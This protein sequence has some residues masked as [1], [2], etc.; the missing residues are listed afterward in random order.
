MRDIRHRP[1]D[2]PMMMGA[3]GGTVRR[4]EGS[5]NGGKKRAHRAATQYALTQLYS[6]IIRQMEDFVNGQNKQMER[7]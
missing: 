3:G 6:L 5:S 7:S 1:R 4:P 2:K